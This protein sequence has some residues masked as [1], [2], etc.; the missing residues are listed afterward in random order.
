[1]SNIKNKTALIGLIVFLIVF[2]ESISLGKDSMTLYWTDLGIEQWN[3]TMKLGDDFSRLNAN[4]IETIVVNNPKGQILIPMP[5]DKDLPKTNEGWNN[6]TSAIYFLL[7][8]KSNEAYASGIKEIEV[9][10]IQSINWKGYFDS[11][12]QDNVVKFTQA[13]GLALGRLKNELSSVHKVVVYG[14]WGSNGGFAVSK[15]LP[16]LEYNPVDNGV[17]ID[18]RAWVSDVKTLYKALNGNLSIINTAGDAPSDKTMVASHDASKDLK[19]QLPDLKVFWVDSKKGINIAD[20]LRSMHWGTSFTVKE[21][22]GNK[23]VNFGEMTGGALCNYILSGESNSIN[24]NNI[25]PAYFVSPDSKYPGK[26]MNE[27]QTLTESVHDKNK[28][29]IVGK[30]P[31]TDLMYKNMV[32][33]LGQDNVKRID[34]YNDD[35]DLQ[36]EARRFGADVILGTKTGGVYIDPIP[37]KEGKGGSETKKKVLESRPSEGTLFWDYQGK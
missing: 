26:S 17:L 36:L 12:R 5:T 27:A 25:I 33:K 2:S 16:I 31:E 7:K 29:I 30:G 4:Q 10:T 19:S 32:N 15:A 1:M 13:F 18:A 37:V 22:T 9:R 14:L 28:A 20:H 8:T 11:G 6:L 23:Y 34:Q 24:Q 21:F 3:S 35:K